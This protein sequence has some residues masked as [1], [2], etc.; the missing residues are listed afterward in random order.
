MLCLI[1][2]FLILS[3]LIVS[4]VSS[5]DAVN[6]VVSAFFSIEMISG[7]E[8]N[9]SVELDV[10]KIILTG[11]TVVYDSDDIKSLANE[12][13]LILGAIENE[14]SILT[15]QT[16]AE[17]FENAEIYAENVLPTYENHKF[18][19][20]FVVNLTATF[21]ELNNSVSSYELVNGILDMG[22]NVTYNIDLYAK[23]GWNNTYEFILSEKMSLISAN[24]P[25][26][27]NDNTY[28]TWFLHNYGGGE[29]TKGVSLKIH[30]KNPTTSKLKEEN[31][32]LEF[33]IDSLEPKSTELQITTNLYQLYIKEYG[34]VPSFIENLNYLPADGVRLF[35][36][37][38]LFSWDDF[39]EKTLDGIKNIIVENIE[40]SVFNQSL[41]LIFEWDKQTTTECANSYDLNK[42]DN[43]P[44]I[45]SILTDGGVNIKI[46]DI[47]SQAVFGL[48]NSCALVNIT[49]G[50][51][52]F[53]EKIDNI[54]YEYNISL[55]MPEGVK[56]NS[57]NPYIWNDSVAFSGEAVSDNP[58][59]YT[60]EEIHT[61]IEIEIENTDLN[62][63]S[64]FTGEP[65]LNF[66]LKMT[67]NKN[68]N[69][70]RLPNMFSIPDKINIDFLNSDALRVCLQEE[71]FEKENIDSFL[72]EDKTVFEAI[73]KKIM[74]NIEVKGN[75]NR[76]AF[77]ESLEW[78][79]NISKMDSASPVKTVS[80]SYTSQPV[81]FDMKIVPPGISIPSQTYNFSGIK[82]QT[83]TYRM[84]FQK[85]I[86]IDVKDAE[87]KAISKQRSDG[88]QYL[89]ITFTP[90]NADTSIVVSCSITPSLLFLIGLFIPCIISIFITLILI[91]V[92]AI[93]R[94]K[95]RGR[96][97]PIKYEEKTYEET[98]AGYED[99]NYYIP[100]PPGS[101]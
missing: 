39:K 100:P 37:N 21:F 1:S 77:D 73:T 65:E 12:N 92:L 81:K 55:H 79:E 60:E 74:K 83:V 13:S 44:P 56:I 64:F 38:Q 25:N 28:I 72:M 24:T 15:S 4:N 50:S 5:E 23:H 93:F 29:G 78:D 84:F 20:N 2:L 80:Y 33:K 53:G 58:P 101:K 62:L 16:L 22:A 98:E 88:S 35:A 66:G 9:I 48:I 42:M 40:T 18:Y 75:I 59:E 97:K 17:S 10:E 61:I 43:E 63:L 54:G 46:F 90:D 6:T 89:E 67:Q 82:N 76:E 32:F 14:L 96:A 11:R 49:D 70:T 31:V 69:I 99:Q 71:V 94:R 8:L 95:R 3:S 41:D 85:G 87:D 91:I 45:K 34:V 27:D 36:K 51:I 86:N 47:S 57:Q 19:D 68:Y 7:T 26:V 52:N 30:G